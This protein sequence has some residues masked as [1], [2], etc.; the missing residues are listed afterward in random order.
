MIKIYNCIDDYLKKLENE[1][2]KLLDDTSMPLTI[3]NQK[4]EPLALQKK[5]L[6]K[7]KEDLIKIEETNFVAECKMYTKG[8][9]NDK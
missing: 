3:K 5:V 2:M 6:L 7:T 4:M 8:N 1:V 9:T